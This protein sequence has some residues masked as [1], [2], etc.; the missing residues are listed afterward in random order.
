ML[1]PK[2]H[3]RNLALIKR[4]TKILTGIAYLACI[5]AA[6]AQA[7]DELIRAVRDNNLNLLKTGDVNARD[8]RGNTLLM[9]AA[10]FGSADAVRLLLDR[11]AEV[12]AKN[13]FGATAL[14]FG[15]NDP[16]KARLLIAKGSSVKVATSSGRTPLMTAATCDG[17]ADTVRLL[18]SR[19]AAAQSADVVGNTSLSN[20]A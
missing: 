9:R 16:E 2:K 6:L 17:C 3:E 19:G 20:A 7:P 15:A 12:D 4:P 11:G 18:L 5:G 1:A 13:Q 10:A 8:A 14:I